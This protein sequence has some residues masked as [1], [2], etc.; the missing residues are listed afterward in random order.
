[1]TPD[2][3]EEDT[4][5][6]QKTKQVTECSGQSWYCENGSIFLCSL[7]NSFYRVQRYLLDCLHVQGWKSGKLGYKLCFHETINMQKHLQ[8]THIFI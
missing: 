6:K 2:V 4:E 8:F 7:S 5:A 1:M 3:R